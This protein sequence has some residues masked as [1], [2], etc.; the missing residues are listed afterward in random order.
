MNMLILNESAMN[1]LKYSSPSFLCHYCYRKSVK[2]LLL[3]CHINSALTHMHTHMHMF[4]HVHT[5]IHIKQDNH[6]CLH[7]GGHLQFLYIYIGLTIQ[8]SNH[9]RHQLT[10]LT[11]EQSALNSPPNSQAVINSKIQIWFTRAP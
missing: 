5:Y 2:H 10:F 3:Y 8:K 4:V 1:L 9:Y 11:S 6:G 7:G